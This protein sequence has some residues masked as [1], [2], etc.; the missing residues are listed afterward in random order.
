M[1]SA[2]GGTLIGGYVIE[3]FDLVCSNIIRMCLFSAM[4]T[5]MSMAFIL[6]HCSNVPFAG[7]STQKGIQSSLKMKCNE[8]CSCSEMLYSPICGADNVTYFSPCYAGCRKDYVIRDTVVYSDCGCISS[9]LRKDPMNPVSSTVFQ[10]ELT[11]CQL[12]CNAIIP[13]CIGLFLALFGTFLNTAPGMSATI[14]CVGEPS[15]SVALGLQWVSV[16]LF[17]TIVAPILFGSMIDISC[18]HW[19]TLCKGQRGSCTVY[20]NASMSYNMYGFLIFLKTMSVLFFF[21]AWVSYKP[22]KPVSPTGAPD[23][24]LVAP[25]HVAPV[26]PVKP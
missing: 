21:A 15:K 16:R 26:A 24:P 5:W 23:E 20:E 2:C 18:I 25:V 13:F 14:R 6:L 11:R 22:A 17:G 10:A 7:I 4:F 1:P 9:R 8:N 3:K 19:Q 12:T